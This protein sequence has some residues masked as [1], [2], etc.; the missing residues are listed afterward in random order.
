LAAISLL[1]SV[2]TPRPAAAWQ[3]D[4]SD[5]GVGLHWKSVAPYPVLTRM[6]PDVPGGGQGALDAALKVW[7]APCAASVWA[8]PSTGWVFPIVYWGEGWPHGAGNA[9]YTE[10]FSDADSGRLKSVVIHLN[11]GFSFSGPT[12][13]GKGAALSRVL[14]HELGHALGIGH[15]R[16]REAL[17]YPAIMGAAATRTQLGRDDKE[18]L[19]TIYP[20]DVRLLTASSGIEYAAPQGK[21]PRADSDDRGRPLAA[22]SWLWI[23]A[24]VVAGLGLVSAWWRRRS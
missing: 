14:A 2:G 19:C 6:I 24:G 15:S 23:L 21:E 7:E 8:D 1:V 17:M 5:H 4:I 22:P 16:H 10:R 9:A 20:S 11:G 18:A 13:D 3:R 12:A